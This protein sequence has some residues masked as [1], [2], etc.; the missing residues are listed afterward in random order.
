MSGVVT[1]DLI[2]GHIETMILNF[3]NVEDMY[4]YQLSKELYLK[5][6]KTY[7]L[8]EATLYSSLKKLE[9]DGCIESYWGEESHGGRRKYYRITKQGKVILN[10]NIENWIKTKKLV[11]LILEVEE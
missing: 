3:L 6:Q 8:K 1:S 10:T 4:G 9:K 2:R 5:S 7:E 11:N